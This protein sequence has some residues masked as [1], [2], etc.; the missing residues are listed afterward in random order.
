[1]VRTAG[2]STSDSTCVTKEV[3]IDNASHQIRARIIGYGANQTLEEAIGALQPSF[4]ART[5]QDQYE[6]TAWWVIERC[7]PERIS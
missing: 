3:S 7:K 5:D 2:T 1:M 6:L 4:N